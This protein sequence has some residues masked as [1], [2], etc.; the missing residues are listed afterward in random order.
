MSKLGKV[1][2]VPFS[3]VD[4]IEEKL[5]EGKISG[6]RCKKC[7]GIY[8]PPRM[9]CPECLDEEMEWVDCEKRG[10][11]VTYTTIHA[12]PAGFEEDAPYTICL[13]DV[14]G[15]G[16]LIGWLDGSEEDIGIGM[17]VSIGIR[18][19]PEDRML[20]SVSPEE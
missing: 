17:N 16:R 11:L 9:D 10:I 13:V 19:L 18:E 5:K 2:F 1:D 7:M 15:G 14:E 12:A 4:G 3:K 8:L 6:T 20:Y